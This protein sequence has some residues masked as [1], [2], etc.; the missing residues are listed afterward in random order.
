MIHGC[1]VL[2]HGV[3]SNQDRAWDLISVAF[4]DQVALFSDVNRLSELLGPGFSTIGFAPYVTNAFY[5][6]E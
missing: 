5:T 2:V 4:F 1:H 3:L 6:S